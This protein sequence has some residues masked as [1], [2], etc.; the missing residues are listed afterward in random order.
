MRIWR[1]RQPG[2]GGSEASDAALAD[3]PITAPPGWEPVYDGRT[4]AEQA[5]VVAVL[6]AHELL[7]FTIM[8]PGP[9]VLEQAA[10]SLRL[11]RTG[12]AAALAQIAVGPVGDA[13]SLLLH[14]LHQYLMVAMG[15]QQPELMAAAAEAA[16]L[17]ATV[18]RREP[19]YRPMPAVELLLLAEHL[20]ENER[21]A[22]AVVVL[23]QAITEL[24][25][26]RRRYP[27][28]GPA[29]LLAAQ[30][31]LSRVAAAAAA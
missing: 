23:D 16:K 28:T 24:R 18:S 21:L 25:G 19:A 7:T 27:G 9:G 3:E 14:A 8:R 26:L 17:A 1:R 29:A 15:T 20:T 4:P 30:R 6:A 5:L 22:D 11:N 12:F 2:P 31:A 10:E 13:D